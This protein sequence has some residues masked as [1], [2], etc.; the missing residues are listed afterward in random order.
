MLS[1]LHSYQTIYFICNHSISFDTFLAGHQ[2]QCVPCPFS[3][4]ISLRFLLLAGWRSLF[5][6]NRWLHSIG[7]WDVSRARVH[8]PSSPWLTDALHAAWPYIIV[9]THVFM[10]A[11]EFLSQFFP[12]WLVSPVAPFLVQRIV[13]LWAKTMSTARYYALLS[14]D[15]DK[16]IDSKFQLPPSQTTLRL[17]SS[18]AGWA[19]ITVIDHRPSHTVTVAFYVS[20]AIQSIVDSDLSENL[21]RTVGISTKW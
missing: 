9:I 1:R 13:S 14:P 19:T 3:S 12:S 4:T 2:R 7:E 10:P 15:S 6:T 21:L 16:P 18:G 17:E 5:G 20:H 11:S 8:H